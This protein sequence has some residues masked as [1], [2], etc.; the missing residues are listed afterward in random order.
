ATLVSVDLFMLSFAVM[1]WHGYFSFA[2][3][4]FVICTV[5]AAPWLIDFAPPG[6]RI[7]SYVRTLPSFTTS[8]MA[9]RMRSAFALS[10]TWSSIMAAERIIAIGFTMGGFNSAYFGAEPCVGSNTATS[11]PIFPD[12][13]KPNPPT[14]PAKA[15]D[16]IS[17][18]RLDARSEERRVGKEWRG[19][20][21]P[22]QRE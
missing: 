10:P 14:N 17:P 4:A 8:A 6:I 11:S 22:R 15:S 16:K 2:R 13:A 19:E 1:V 21:A 18:K 20:G 3:I 9:L 12:A 7:M 5:E